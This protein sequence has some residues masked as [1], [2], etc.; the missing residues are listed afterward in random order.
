MAEGFLPDEGGGGLASEVWHLGE[1]HAFERL[2]RHILFDV[3]TLHY[4]ESTPV[5]HALVQ[6]L[7][8]GTDEPVRALRGC[9]PRRDVHAAMQQLREC[10]L[11]RPGPAPAGRARPR[12][13][14]RLGIRHLELMVTHACNMRCRYCYGSDD[15]DGWQGAEHLYGSSQAGMSWD[16]ARK[17]VD[18]LFEASGPQKE[19]SVIF[20]G[21]E[22]L[23]EFDLIKRV[24]AY[25]RAKERDT[26]KRVDFSLSSNGVNLSQEVVDFLVRE[27]ISC[28]VSIDGP[29]TIHDQNRV[30]ASG[31]GSY[32]SVMHGVRRLL[33]KRPGRVSARVTVAAG[34]VD[35]PKVAD[36]LL[37]LGF[38]S[39]HAEPVIGNACGLALKEA[40]LAHFEQQ[41]EHLA[42]YL[43]RR[44]RDGRI[45]NFSNLVRHVRQIRVIDQRL[46][47]YCGAARTYLA[48]DQDGAFYPCHRFVG[49]P[50]YRMGD[51]EIGF[52]DRLQKR[53]LGLTVDDRPGCKD[54]WARYLCGGGC[55][56]H[57]VDVNG[58]LERP[59]EATSC[60]LIKHQIECAMAITGALRVEDK[61]LLGDAY[62]RHEEPY[63]LPDTGSTS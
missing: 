47:H 10:G 5:V 59:D 17:G 41:T 34:R 39:I 2:G 20:F 27:D 26:G 36:H 31:K 14:K 37:N 25:V 16:T 28:Q 24:V 43:V 23:L 61:E 63:K 38:G 57:A 52:D 44:V 40:D 62:A 12:L 53:I 1:A 15:H 49:M 30:L 3:D 42:K 50:E 55:W 51:L 18:F 33:D 19:L 13:R 21:G 29:A 58:G 46:A 54:C 32:D 4:Y 48:L 60:R 11:L 9:F 7:Q 56:K 8:A 6:A 35:L 45:F 22:P